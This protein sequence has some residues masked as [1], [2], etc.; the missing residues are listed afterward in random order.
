MLLNFRDR[1]PKRTYRGAIEL[2]ITFIIVEILSIRIV[3]VR[4]RGESLVSHIVCMR[5][6]HFITC[7]DDYNTQ[8]LES[9]LSVHLT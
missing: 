1:T 8:H 7:Y 3:P 2:L 4:S 6:N 9:V 5:M